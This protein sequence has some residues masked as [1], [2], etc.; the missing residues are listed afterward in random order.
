ML[1]NLLSYIII[2]V[3]T[4]LFVRGSNWFT[5]NFSVIG[6]VIQRRDAFVLWGLIVGIYFF[7]VLRSIV[8]H[9]EEKPKAALLIPFCLWLLF[10][11]VTTPYLPEELPFKSFL[12]IIFAFLAAVFL[13]ICLY[14]IVWKLYR[15]SPSVYWPYLF[16][17]T[18]ITLGSAFLLFLVGI[19]SSALEIFFTLSAVVLVRRL[20]YR[21]S[22]V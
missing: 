7:W 20:L 10:S 11:A 12:H 2:P 16:A 18:G 15:L 21:V 9:M 17:L 6:N 22:A 13:I 3:Y 4:I 8:R 14:M 5:C 1:L 19:V